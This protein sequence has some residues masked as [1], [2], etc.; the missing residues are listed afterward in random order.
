MSETDKLLNYGDT[1]DESIGDSVEPILNAD[2]DYCNGLYT[3][4]SYGT[5]YSQGVYPK[6][7]GVDYSVND[8]PIPYVRTST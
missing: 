3:T 5:A 2:G 8:D 4:L 1:E 6:E 7:R